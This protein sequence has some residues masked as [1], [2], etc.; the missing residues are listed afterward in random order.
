MNNNKYHKEVYRNFALITQIGISMIA[1]V[2]LM[3][4]AGLY[5]EKKTGLFFT[6]PCLILGF[7][8]GFR[9][10]LILVVKASKSEKNKEMEEEKRLV[11]EAVEKW[12][13]IK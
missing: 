4:A 10:V 3:L 12:N 1:P 2:F 8:A 6:I 7:M 9:N 13:K 11:D 5:L